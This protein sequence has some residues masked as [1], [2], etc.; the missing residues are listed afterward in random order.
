MR[1]NV[2]ADDQAA[3][4]ECL[5]E[6]SGLSLGDLDEADQSSLAH[7]LRQALGPTGADEALTGGGQSAV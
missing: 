2:D 3:P 7:A 4:G 1:E 5:I 6:L